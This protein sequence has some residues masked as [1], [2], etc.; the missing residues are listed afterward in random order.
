MEE[1]NAELETTLSD[2]QRM[3]S[4]LVQSEKMASI[5]QLT[6]GIAH[7]INNP[8]A[9]VSSN[10]N[11]FEEY[12]HDLLTVLKEWQS[13]GSSLS[14]NGHTQRILAM[15]EME[16]KADLAFAIQDFHQLMTHTK[17]AR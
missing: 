17:M 12:F 8:L 15:Q 9:F 4:T 16:K 5:G 13:F 3:Q 6:A 10:L 14:G 7:E 1:R 2:I 11:R